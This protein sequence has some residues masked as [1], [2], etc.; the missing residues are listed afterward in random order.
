M[1]KAVRAARE[2]K[3]LAATGLAF[4]HGYDL[5]DTTRMYCTELI[6]NV[7]ARAGIDITEGRRT[8]IN[9]PGFSGDYILPTDI[10]RN[11]AMKTICEF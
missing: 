8:R 1:R 9:A 3:R 11:P 4:D 5:T 6:Y 10:A 2:A 7:F